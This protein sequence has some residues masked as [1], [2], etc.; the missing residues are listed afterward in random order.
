M[1]AGIA[2]AVF[3]GAEPLTRPQRRR[4]QLS[5]FPLLEFAIESGRGDRG[6]PTGRGGVGAGELPLALPQRRIALRL[7]L[8]PVPPPCPCAERDAD[9]RRSRSG[10]ARGRDVRRT[11]RLG[12]GFP[13]R[14]RPRF[15][16]A[17]AVRRQLT[18]FS[19]CL[20]TRPGFPLP[21]RSKMS[22]L[23]KQMKFDKS[24]DEKLTP[25]VSRAF[26]FVMHTFVRAA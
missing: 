19:Q 17:D 9:L 8:W 25:K 20:V 4:A 24:M 18:S 11:R 1:H 5:D 16:D 2:C 6:G 10:L 12:L 14:A 13:S 7:A 22:L 15:G 3:P 21:A 23:K 26:V